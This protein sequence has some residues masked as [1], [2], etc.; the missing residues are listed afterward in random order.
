MLYTNFPASG[1]TGRFFPPLKSFLAITTRPDIL[2]RMKI[3]TIVVGPFQVNCYLLWTDP[4]RAIGIDPGSDAGVIEETLQQHGVTVSAWLLTHG[5]ADHI[6]ALAELHK[7]HPAPVFLHPAD[8]TWCFSAQNSIEPYYG[9]PTKPHAGILDPTA[10][11]ERTAKKPLHSRKTRTNVTS[12]EGFPARETAAPGFQTLETPGHTPGGVCYYFEK[13]KQLFS[14][15]T[16]FKGSCGRTDLP[17][18][19]GRI[20]A[21]SLRKL[22][23]LPDDVTVHAGHGEPTTIGHEKQTNFFMQQAARHTAADP[24]SGRSTRTI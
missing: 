2:G 19:D 21:Q 13:Q 10:P 8:L 15:D 22:A 12:G 1:S 9:V 5:H 17:G 4:G 7:T 16:L 14:G 18:G 6:S 11:A 3:K 23:A 24:A 20:L